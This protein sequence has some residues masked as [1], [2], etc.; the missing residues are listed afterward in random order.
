MK[1]RK[2]TT[3]P[4]ILSKLAMPSY[5]MLIHFLIFPSFSKVKRSCFG[6]RVRL[7]INFRHQVGQADLYC[8]IGLSHS[9]RIRLKGWYLSCSLCN[10]VDDCR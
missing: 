5:S 1:G 9:F 4:K 10:G 3:G 8:Y 6:F 7:L 2:I